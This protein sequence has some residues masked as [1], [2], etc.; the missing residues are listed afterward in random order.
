MSFSRGGLSR[1]HRRHLLRSYLWPYKNDGPS[2]SHWKIIPSW[3]EERIYHRLNVWRDVSVGYNVLARWP[4]LL[5]FDFALRLQALAHAGSR[6]KDADNDIIHWIAHL[7]SWDCGAA[8][9]H[10]YIGKHKLQFDVYHEARQLSQLFSPGRFR[11]F[12]KRDAA[13]HQ[14]VPLCWNRKT[15]PI[16]LAKRYTCHLRMISNSL[17]LGGCGEDVA[18]P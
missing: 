9:S 13:A 2:R 17:D 10:L 4:I 8:F 12:W 16:N 5:T 6:R 7:R 3:G 15:F 14:W 18:Y 1:Y 11:C